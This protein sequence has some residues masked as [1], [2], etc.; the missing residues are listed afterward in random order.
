[1]YLCVEATDADASASASP[2]A[3]SSMSIYAD[4][5]RAAV[6]A[7]LA[8]GSVILTMFYKR[9]HKLM[10]RALLRRPVLAKLATFSLNSKVLTS[11]INIWSGQCEALFKLNLSVYSNVLTVVLHRA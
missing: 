11:L 5:I 8:D 10:L 9:L 1:M 3:Q 6:T 4:I 2:R 7:A